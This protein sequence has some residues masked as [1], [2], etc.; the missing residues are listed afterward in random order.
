MSNEVRGNGVGEC[1]DNFLTSGSV[2]E[3]REVGSEQIIG[4]AD[5]EAYGE[6]VASAGE[7]RRL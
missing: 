7:W 2:R 1:S 3:D 6:P 4:L 5:R